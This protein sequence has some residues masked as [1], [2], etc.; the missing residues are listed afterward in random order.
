MRRERGVRVQGDGIDAR[1]LGLYEGALRRDP[2]GDAPGEALDHLDAQSRGGTNS[3]TNLT[4]TCHSCNSRKANTTL[5]GFLLDGR[6][7]ADWQALRQLQEL[8][9]DVRAVG[10]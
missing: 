2:C 6:Y 9:A 10:L 8:R 4:A 7:S 5:L 3:Y 1:W